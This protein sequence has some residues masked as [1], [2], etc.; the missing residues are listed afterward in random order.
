MYKKSN[1]YRC[2]PNGHKQHGVE[3]VASNGRKIAECN[4]RAMAD[5][6]I[7]GLQLVKEDEE[8]MANFRL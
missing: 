2:L 7:R 3:I 1:F 6:I 4:T 8:K 5:K